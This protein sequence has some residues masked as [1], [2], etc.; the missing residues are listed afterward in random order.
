VVIGIVRW[1]VRLVSRAVERCR[2]RSDQLGVSSGP[3]MR[4]FA[5]AEQGVIA[6]LASHVTLVEQTLAWQPAGDARGSANVEMT[7]WEQTTYACR[8]SRRMIAGRLHSRGWA[9]GDVVSVRD[10]VRPTGA[11]V[12]AAWSIS[13]R[14]RSV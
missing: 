14:C 7:P 4:L 13:F 12:C 11:L 9:G 1:W 6:T 10:Q 5:A 2:H 3:A 8:R